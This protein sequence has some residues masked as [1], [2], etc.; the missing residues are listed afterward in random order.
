MEQH[1]GYR[2]AVSFASYE[3]LVE[4]IRA[5]LEHHRGDSS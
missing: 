1:V 5:Q 4:F 3:Q 2:R